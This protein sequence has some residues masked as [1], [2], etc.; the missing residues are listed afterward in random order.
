[1]RLNLNLNLKLKLKLKVGAEAQA[2]R[3][4]GRLKDLVGVALPCVDLVGRRGG[5]GTQQ[6][7]GKGGHVCVSER[8]REGPRE[9]AAG[10]TVRGALTA[11]HTRTT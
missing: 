8:A 7:N 5:G 11:L 1:V 10:H 2:G 6:G 9:H 4:G 3:G